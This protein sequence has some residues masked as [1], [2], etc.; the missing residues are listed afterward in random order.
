MIDT[1][2]CKCQHNGKHWLKLCEPHKTEH[3]ATHKR[4]AAEH[5]H[6]T[7]ARTAEEQ[8]WSDLI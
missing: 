5:Q 6:D 7:D 8:I 4:W 2:P 1:L 3:D